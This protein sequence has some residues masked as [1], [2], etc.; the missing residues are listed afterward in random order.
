MILKYPFNSAC[1]D[2]IYSHTLGHTHLLISVLLAPS[3]RLCHRSPRDAGWA[4][5]L[6][7]AVW[8]VV[9]GSTGRGRRRSTPDRLT[10]LAAACLR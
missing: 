5:Q 8:R 10:G 9:A 2:G 3:R 6:F 1:S 4:R 7:A